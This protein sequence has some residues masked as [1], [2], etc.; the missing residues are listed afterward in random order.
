MQTENDQNK[1]H[2]KYSQCGLLSPWKH[3]QSHFRYMQLH[4][5]EHRYIQHSEQITLCQIILYRNPHNSSPTTCKSIGRWTYNI[6]ENTNVVDR[7]LATYQKCVGTSGLV[8][9]F[10]RLK[11]DNDFTKF[12][13]DCELYSTMRNL[14][15]IQTDPLLC[16]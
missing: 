6:L 9:S 7:T 12:L 15:K 5:L 1:F 11:V 14:L 2:P 3:A 13:I 16:I 10:S 4:I 8:C